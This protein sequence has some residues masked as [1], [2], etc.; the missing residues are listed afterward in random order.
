ML[1]AQVLIRKF[2]SVVVLIAGVS[3]LVACGGGGGGNTSESTPPSQ[4]LPASE[5]I[6][7][8]VALDS[9]IPASIA[10]SIVKIS[11]PTETTVLGAPVSVVSAGPNGESIVLAADASDNIVLAA[12]ASTATT[13]LSVD[14]TALVLARLAIGPV[15]QGLSAA[16]VNSFIRSASGYV[17]L[18]AAVSQSLDAGAA[19]STNAAVLQKVAAVAAQVAPMIAG[20]ISPSIAKAAALISNDRVTPPLPFAVIVDALGT[21]PVQITG[22]SGHAITVTNNM[23]IAWSAISTSA[24]GSERDNVLVFAKGKEAVFSDGG[25]GFNLTVEQTSGSRI[26]TMGDVVSKIFNIAVVAIPASTCTTVSLKAGVVALLKGYNPASATWDQFVSIADPMFTPANV[27]KLIEKCVPTPKYQALASFLSPINKFIKGLSIAPASYD[28]YTLIGQISYAKHYY[29]ESRTVGVCQDELRNI[30]N[31]AKSFVFTPKL[32]RAQVGVNLKPHTQLTALDAKG[33]PTAIPAGLI[34][35]AT[36]G[37][38]F[39]SV[40]AGT[41]DTLTKKAG[42]SS[43]IVTDPA[44]G[45]TGGYDV[46]IE[47]PGVISPSTLNLKVGETGRLNLTNG[48]ENKIILAPGTTWKVTNESIAQLNVLSGLFTGQPDFMAKGPGTTTVTVTNPVSGKQAVAVITVLPDECVQ[49]PVTGL[50]WEGGPNWQNK[51]LLRTNYDSTTE[52]QKFVPVYGKSYQWN[53]VAPTQAEVDSL[54]NSIGYKNSINAQGL[55]GFSDWR[56]PTADELSAS[57]LFLVDFGIFWSSS[58]PSV[59]DLLNYGQDPVPSAFTWG[60]SVGTLATSP[61]VYPRVRGAPAF[62]R[63]VRTGQ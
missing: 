48:F 19:P 21:S 36:D 6:K 53:Y 52:L 60:V 2:R 43:I 63:L 17:N 9:A 24:S 14:S 1:R 54:N 4:S 29:V 35:S 41:G 33:N 46:F 22:S 31:C 30:I 10:A 16:Q 15:P 57:T 28:A 59:S 25:K 45:A 42:S 47:D 7:T 32:L 3:V 49:D 8:A 58:S 38:S 12:L 34:Y 18:V 44:T 40:D 55:C 37:N 11:S 56:L 20:A 62:V 26:D 39:L 5:E 23:P 50:M 51:S 61:R 13:T 27:L